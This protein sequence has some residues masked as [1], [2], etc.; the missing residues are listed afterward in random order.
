MK[1]LWKDIK[2]YE[3]Y[4]QVS[5]LG[6]VRSVDRWV[7]NSGDTKKFLKGRIR[8]L[9]YLN[10]GYLVAHLLKEGKSEPYYVHRLVAEAFIPNPDNLPIINHKDEVKTNNH[11]DNLEWCTYS[12]NSNYGTAIER[13][14]KN[15]EGRCKKVYQYNLDGEF[16]RE[17]ESAM[18]VERQL[19]YSDSSIVDC[20]KGKSKTAYKHI[21]SFTP[22]GDKSLQEAILNAKKVVY[23]YTIDGKLVKKWK[24]V[25]EIKKQ[26][27]YGSSVSSC[28]SGKNKTAYGYIWRHTPIPD[29]SYSDVINKLITRV[30]KGLWFDEDK[31]RKYVNENYFILPDMLDHDIKI[32][33]QLRDSLNIA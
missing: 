31:M 7:A 11:V 30:C 24:S 4:Y 8:K 2:G 33:H 3:G 32:L 15:N 16:I 13:A 28:C 23:Q 1:E 26:L 6:R 17:W 9:N 22:L 21:W 27:G 19:G 29:K 18:E 25:T 12:Y 5:N 20:C 10:N 14:R